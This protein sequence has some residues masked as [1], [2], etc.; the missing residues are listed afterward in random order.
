MP[1]NFGPKMEEDLKCTLFD[2]S[3]I[4][5]KVA[6]IGAKITQDYEGKKPLVVGVLNGAAVFMTDLVRA[7]NTPVEIDFISVSSYGKEAKSGELKFRKDV[8]QDVTGRHIIFVEDI[9]DT[10]RTLKAVMEVYTSRGAASISVCT[11]LDKKA[12]RVADI[13]V[14]YVGFDCPD[15]F[16]VGYG[17]DYAEHYRNLP[18]IAALKPSVYE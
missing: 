17:I 5:K 3:V 8:D 10:G 15:E 14:N 11:L 6:E 16:V 12:H 7:I 2:V 4:S 9:I 18:Y 13:Q 1:Q